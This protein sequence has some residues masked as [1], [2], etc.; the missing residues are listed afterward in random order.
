MTDVDVKSKLT[1]D[2]RGEV[3]MEMQFTYMDA[4]GSNPANGERDETNV[5]TQPFAAR[6]ETATEAGSKDVLEEEWIVPSTSLEMGLTSSNASRLLIEYG[7]NEVVA[8]ET[9]EWRKIAKRYVA[10]VPLIMMLAAALSIAVVGRCNQEDKR[11][12]GSC[13]CKS[14]R[15]W[16]S[17]FLLVFEV[18]LIVIV[19]YIGEANSGNA[20]KE[21]KRMAA[22]VANV[23]R[24]GEW[25]KCPVAELV[26]GDV[27]GLVIG[28][29]VPADGVLVGEGEPLKLDVA[30]LTG[31]P[32]PETKRV[33]DRVLGGSL[34]LSGELEMVVCLTG[35]KSTMGQAM[36]LIAGV[37]E[38]GGNLKRLLSRL[39]HGI[40]LG[41]SV[42][43]VILFFVR[44]QRDNRS[45]A[46]SFKFAVVI[47]VAVLPVAM[48]VVITTGLAVG[49]LE[50][51]RHKAIVQRLS[52]IEELAG[53]DIL[54]S[55]KTG[56]LTLGKMSIDEK[57]CVVFDNQIVKTTHE[58]MVYALLASR[59]ENTDAIDTAINNYFGTGDDKS[60]IAAIAQFTVNRF[61][62]FN[63][64]D[65]MT[66]AFVKGVD[67][68]N[69][70]VVKGAPPVINAM[71]SISSDVRSKAIEVMDDCA[72]RGLKTLA[73][74]YSTDEQH[75][76]ML[77]YL[78]LIDPPRHDTKATIV[79]AQRRG[80]E[81]KMITGD[82]R[83][84]G[85]EVARRL[86]MGTNIFGPEIW[87]QGSVANS[88]ID[89]AGG[90]ANL[91]LSANG[92]A[93]VHPEHKY[94]V[95]E[96]LQSARHTVGMTGD[97]VNDAPALAI[98]NV[99]I[100]V[101]D[102]TDAARGAADIVLT[103]EG[104]STI[105]IAIN[106][107]RIIFRR[108][109]SYIIYR[110]ASSTLILG[111]FT[112]MVTA[113]N[114]EFPTWVLI[115][116]SIVNDF[117][118]I[119]PESQLFDLWLFIVMATSKD[120]M[121]TSTKPLHWDVPKLC[122]IAATIGGV[123][124]VQ[125]FL[126]LHLM[127]SHNRVFFWHQESIEDCRIVAAI[128]LDLAI[129]IQ[130]NIFSARTRRFIFDF[131]EERD[132]APPPS[133]ILIAPVLGAIIGSTFLAVYWPATV[134]LGS[135]AALRGLTWY[136]AGLVWL[137]AVVWYAIVE[138][139]KVSMYRLN[140]KRGYESLF[141]GSLLD[142]ELSPRNVD[143]DDN[144]VRRRMQRNLS[145]YRCNP[146]A[147]GGLRAVADEEN[148]LIMLSEILP[149]PS[150][151]DSEVLVQ[152]IAKMREHILSL[153]SRLARLDGKEIQFKAD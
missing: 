59:L 112:L 63:P 37:T 47:L 114:F 5:D 23:K 25:T 88:A 54:C 71:P 22:P 95:V 43:C 148:N 146:S 35:D 13:E 143:D 46:D 51:S 57:S 110:L 81:V 138:V 3:D 2:G 49:A 60:K 121:R 64:N 91:A 137:W 30:A 107:S 132:A 4:D 12:E 29:A 115:L 76:T 11:V 70:V 128:Y 19:D 100:A 149:P 109:E 89:R 118:V 73:V 33:G 97:G 85:I 144:A 52:A 129:T 7:R 69:F 80:V 58:L 34:V 83:K 67:D 104:L 90:L 10:L 103:Q 141:Y 120:N 134:R 94:K 101:A 111:F 36:A 150:A 75:W 8:P 96:A 74:A 39:A 102:A 15:D 145:A 92:F 32:L 87:A 1:R 24:D 116:L 55:D 45:F 44:L 66:Q 17:F 42:V 82:Q 130:L 140:G 61:I 20:I 153:E 106:K 113:T 72:A 133:K 40:A 151:L 26:P 41:A 79:E 108:L 135:G 18:N 125:S 142:D 31:E 139:A 84:I 16:A 78:A 86:H 98:A 105:V 21:L 62:P 77:G 50:L 126:F 119:L 124:V 65:K 136:T 38:Q 28:A 152:Y 147:Y 9:P 6:M 123:G 68:K 48:P 99:G 131:R 53:M 56:T 127:K 117:T 93:G 27:V 14:S 122:L